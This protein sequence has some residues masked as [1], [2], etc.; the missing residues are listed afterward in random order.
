VA[1]SSLLLAAAC[2]TLPL[3]GAA[4]GEAASKT[5]A[6]KPAPASETPAAPAKDEN[7]STERAIGPGDILSIYIVGEKDLPPDFTVSPE[8]VI[9]FPFLETVGVKGK[10]CAEVKA[11]ITRALALDYFVDPQVFVAIKQ[12]RK[13]FVRVLG[14]VRKQGAIELPTDR[15][16]DVIDALTA[17]EGLTAVAS[18]KKIVVTHK[19]RSET[20]NLDRLKEASEKVWLEPD[21]I[22]DVGES[23]L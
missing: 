3:L 11:A 18:K 17:A 20:Y 15:K 13:Q 22:I 12:Y 2:G 8:G 23:A 1:A 7:R 16:F 5:A 6:A 21:D 10:T 19:G 14:A 9:Q 4:A